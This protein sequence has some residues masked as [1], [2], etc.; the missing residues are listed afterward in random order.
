[1]CAASQQKSL[2]GLDY[3]TEGSQARDSCVE[4][5]RT[6]AEVG[7]SSEWRN[8]TRESIDSCKIYL[9]SDYK[10]HPGMSDRCADHCVTLAL[11]DS[12]SVEYCQQCQHGDEHDLICE[13]CQEIRTIL[14]K[15]ESKIMFSDTSL[16]EDQRAQQ[17][18]AAE[19]VMLWKAHTVRIFNQGRAMQTTLA[20]MDSSSVLP[21]VVDWAMKLLPMHYRE[22]MTDF[23]GKRGRSWHVAC[24]IQKEPDSYLSVQSFVHVFDDCTQDKVALLSILKRILKTIKAEKPVIRKAHLQSDNAGCYHNPLNLFSMKSLS[25]RTYNYTETQNGKGICDRKTASMKQHI[26]RYVNKIHDVII[27]SEIREALHSHDS[28]KV[29]GFA[30]LK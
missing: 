6:L 17:H 26:R 23:F 5:V 11:G 21:N 12:R 1:M 29:A 18:I 13:R 27:A 19:A 9:K 30:L 10:A 4:I 16:T 7:A 15:V 28:V 2:Q 3:I 8:E 14:Q 20:S 25:R 24:V 22:A